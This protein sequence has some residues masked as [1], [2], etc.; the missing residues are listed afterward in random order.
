MLDLGAITATVPLPVWAAGAFAVLFVIAGVM[1]LQRSATG[2][3]IAALSRLAVVVIAA[4]LAGNLIDRSATQERAAE[5]HALDARAGELTARAI[6]PGS[7]LACL[8]ANA[9]EAVENSCEK[10]LFATPEAVAAANSYVSAR[11]LL[12]ADGLSY[13][14]RADPSYETA[15][16][17]LRRAIEADRFG[18]VAHVLAMRDACTP[19]RCDGLSLLRDASMV[20]ANLKAHTYENYVA[21]YAA[22]W[23]EQKAAPTLSAVPATAPAVAAVP[24]SIDF[25]S[26]ASIPP[27]SIMTPEPG[28]AAAVPAE[29]KASPP[30]KTAASAPPVSRPA[31]NAAPILIVPLPTA[32]AANPPRSP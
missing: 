10:A 27:V 11:L 25:P 15:L 32:S 16:A 19:E 4:W 24:K 2:G 5:R 7:A 14:S 28:A 23:L 31:T 13:A 1:A 3:S 20:M 26:A 30:P 8:D 18:L 22:I 9:G 6:M 21:R 29:P 17:G 12:L